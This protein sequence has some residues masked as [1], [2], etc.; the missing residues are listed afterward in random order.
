M[1]YLRIT[2]IFRWWRSLRNCATTQLSLLRVFIAHKK[3]VGGEFCVCTGH[4]T[5]GTRNSLVP[6]D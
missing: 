1:K 6:N 5:A 2:V 3:S 4:R